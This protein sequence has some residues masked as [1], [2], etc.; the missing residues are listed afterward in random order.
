VRRLLLLTAAAI[1]LTTTFGY[2]AV[3]VDGAAPRVYR[4]VGLVQ[5]TVVLIRN[6]TGRPDGP[7]L[8][9]PHF[10][11]LVSSLRARPVPS[12][13]GAYLYVLDATRRMSFELVATHRGS[14]YVAAVWLHGKAV[15]SSARWSSTPGTSAAA[16]FELALIGS[17]PHVL[18]RAT[19]TTLQLTAAGGRILSLRMAPVP[20]A[21]RN[22]L[23]RLLEGKLRLAAVTAI[24]APTA[25]P[26]ATPA[27]PTPSPTITATAS[28][29]SDAST[30]TS[31]AVIRAEGTDQWIPSSVSIRPGSDVT[32]ENADQ[33]DHSIQ[34]VQRVGDDPCPWS[35]VL[36]LPPSGRVTVTFSRPGI[37]AFAD[38]HRPA[39]QG[40][41]VVGA[42]H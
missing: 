6:V 20:N 24:A 42:P 11:A 18:I 1:A 27:R 22:V 31:G 36:S 25:T 39:M 13:H 17:T 10:G 2:R 26:T 15:V 37:Y 38:V 16:G 41:I 30:P 35:G 29:S 23:P 7:G 9:A 21:V 34:C 12:R 33:A 28:G 8:H 4:H 40:E 14:R 19:R 5:E 32:W 3:R